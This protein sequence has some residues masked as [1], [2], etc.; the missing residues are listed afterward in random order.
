[1]TRADRRGLIDLE[2]VE[3]ATFSV[4]CLKPTCAPAIIVFGVFV[5]SGHLVVDLTVEEARVLIARFE[6]VMQEIA[7]EIEQVIR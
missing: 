5:T 2:E 3:R 6:S 7:D 4:D 1:M